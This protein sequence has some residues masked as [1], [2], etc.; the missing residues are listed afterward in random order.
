V[1]VFISSQG[2]TNGGAMLEAKLGNATDDTLTDG[3]FD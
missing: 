1:T 3:G 2:T